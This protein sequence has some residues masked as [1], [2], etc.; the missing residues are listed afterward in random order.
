V[1]KRLETHLFPV[2]FEGRLV[3][4]QL[5]ADGRELLMMLQ[6]AGS[7]AAPPTLRIVSFDLGMLELGDLCIE[8]PVVGT[9]EPRF[10]LGP[11]LDELGSDYAFVL[12]N[13]VLSLTTGAAV[14]LLEPI[15][16][17]AGVH[18]AQIVL[19]VRDHAHLAAI[20]PGQET[21][22]LLALDND[23]AQRFFG[24]PCARACACISADRLETSV[25]R[26]RTQPPPRSST[27]SI[28]LVRL[29]R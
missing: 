24:A 13:N 10:V 9:V 5:S 2:V 6:Y 7:D 22:Y 1:V 4:Q 18:L 29:D 15:K 28:D 25:R 8:L 20:A 16:H 3:D 19:A 26:P 21:V 17:T 12:M 11:V 14:C 27:L 23:P